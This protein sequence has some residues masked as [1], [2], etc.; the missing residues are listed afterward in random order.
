MTLAGI[1]QF[2]ILVVVV[3]VAARMVRRLL[4]SRIL[5]RVPMGMGAKDAVARLAGYF[6]LVL[7]LM[8][9]LQTLG[10]DLTALTVLAGALG[11]GI[12]FGLQNIVNNF[13][14]G[15]IIL[16]ERPIQLGD[17]VEVGG[18]QGDVVRIGGRSTTIRT[19]DNI[20]MIIPNAEF[21]SAQVVNL[22][23]GDRKVRIRIPFGVS[24]A[25]EPRQV[26]RLALEVAAADRNVLQDPPPSVR[27]IGFGD[28]SLEFE[29]RAWT[30]DLAHRPGLFRSNLNFALWEQFKKHG[31]E[32][33]FP[34]RDLHFRNSLRIEQAPEPDRPRQDG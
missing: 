20:D 5:P 29:L 9:A 14:S 6:V 28:S 4:R 1:I 13:M 34:Q 33:P 15:L 24:Y 8:V 17:R 31:I 21:I 19:N 27:F 7:G 25:S 16:V 32:I 3:L 23:Y 11:I 22:S 26:E 2:F 10:I 30:I 18:V 12:G